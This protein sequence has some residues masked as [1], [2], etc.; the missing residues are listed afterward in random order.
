MPRYHSSIRTH[1][2]IR[3]LLKEAGID[4][5]RVALRSIEG[6]PAKTKHVV[7]IVGKKVTIFCSDCV[8]KGYLI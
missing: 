4:P 6:R 3:R 5:D 7:K 8:A 2:E 1:P